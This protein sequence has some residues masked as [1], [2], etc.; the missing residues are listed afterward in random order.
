MST[1]A[2]PPA[3]R[4]A[5]KQC[6]I[7]Q[8]TFT[9]KTHLN[10]HMRSHTNDRSHKCKLCNSQFTRSDLLTRHK[11][12][13]GGLKS[14]Q[15]CAKAKSRCDLQTPS[16]SKCISRGIECE[17]VTGPAARKNPD[18]PSA[19]SGIPNFAVP[20]FSPSSTKSPFDFDADSLRRSSPSSDSS[21]S[22]LLGADCDSSSVC[23][24][25]GDIWPTAAGLPDFACQTDPSLTNIV[26]ASAALFEIPFTNMNLHSECTA[27]INGMSASE[28]DS[29]YEE[30]ERSTCGD[31]YKPGWA[32]EVTSCSPPSIPQST[33]PFPDKTWQ[34]G[35]IPQLNVPPLTTAQIPFL[36]CSPLVNTS[37]LP[38][39]PT[40][41]QPHRGLKPPQVDESLLDSFQHLFLTDFLAQLPILHTPSWNAND[42]PDVLIKAMQACGALYARTAES[43]KLVTEVL[44]SGREE[45]IMD[46]VRQTDPMHQTYLILA[47]VLIQSIGLFHQSAD[48]RR[49]SAIYHAMIA[50]MVNRSP[51]FQELLQWSLP[52]NFLFTSSLD[53]VWRDWVR[54]ETA[55][56]VLCLFYLHDC[57]QAIFFATPPTG[58]LPANLCLPCEPALWNART[59]QEWYACLQQSSHYGSPATRL[60]G[61]DLQQAWSTLL[62][63]RPPTVTTYTSAFGHL[64]LAHCALAQIFI[65]VDTGTDNGAGLPLCS[66]KIGSENVS[67]LT[68]YTMRNALHNWLLNWQYEGLQCHGPESPVTKLPFTEDALPFYWLGQISLFLL[69]EGKGRGPTANPDIR[70]HVVKEWLARIRECLGSQRTAPAQ[71]MSG[72]VKLPPHY[73]TVDV[74]SPTDRLD[75]LLEL[76]PT[77][78]S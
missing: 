44:K 27:E 58:C 17:Y 35:V 75:G 18:N 53:D 30:L 7:C 8:A 4:A 12:I 78:S 67:P 51:A 59:S 55:K 9:R 60:K 5:T 36:Q 25:P 47:L 41:T 57:C 2:S 32:V 37:T 52:I 66:A 42:K 16:C 49:S 46:F 10:R 21:S 73:P 72:L 61:L 68:L 74:N 6:E 63:Q 54:Y 69:C 50:P 33:Y 19:T 56:R 77:L 64:I 65:R 20:P 29:L 26:D 24:S 62:E 38:G 23:S 40:P 45:I 1:L 70:F 13:C 43:D 28:W 39:I 76:F 11:K 22:S 15:A 71:C 34:S 31:Y 48:Q 3:R 14:C